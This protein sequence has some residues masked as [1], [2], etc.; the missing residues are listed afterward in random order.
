MAERDGP[1]E[2][3]V[4]KL[5]SERV[6]YPVLGLCL[7]AVM[8]FVIFRRSNQGAAPALDLAVID[9]RGEL[10]AER[11]RLLKRLNK[12]ARVGDPQQ[13]VERGRPAER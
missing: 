7:A 9:E 2:T 8:A 13:R 10:G 1:D 5:L 12:L 3:L 6:L 4:D 11:V